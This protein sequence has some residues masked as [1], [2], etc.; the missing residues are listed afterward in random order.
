MKN[1]KLY[2]IIGLSLFVVFILLNIK[3]ETKFNKYA[4]TTIDKK[5][6]DFGTA[7][8]GDTI[9]QVYHINNVSKNLFVVTE[10]DS[11]DDVSFEGTILN[12]PILGGETKSIVVQ[13]VP[14]TKGRVLRVIEV[15]SNSTSG[16][17]KLELKGTI[18]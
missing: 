10:V 17:I 2:V 4:K 9:M 18:K 1:K 6:I 5:M 15:I 3:I 14:E 13:F 12:K 7:K 11:N 8:V 16:I